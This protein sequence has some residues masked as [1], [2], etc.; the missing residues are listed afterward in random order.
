MLR[1]ANMPRHSHIRVHR[2]PDDRHARRVAAEYVERVVAHIHAVPGGSSQLFAGKLQDS[3]VGLIQANLLGDDYT[4]KKSVQPKLRKMGAHLWGVI[5][6]NTQ[7]EPPGLQP[8]KGLHRPKGRL[9][10]HKVV[11]HEH[12][13]KLSQGFLRQTQSV[14]V[15]PEDIFQKLLVRHTRARLILPLYLLPLPEL[16]LGIGPLH[17]LKSQPR[18]KRPGRLIDLLRD[19]RSFHKQGIVNIKEHT[20]NQCCHTFS[21]PSAVFSPLISHSAVYP[22]S[23]PQTSPSPSTSPRML[24]ALRFS[25]SST[26]WLP[27][28]L[29]LI[30]S[31]T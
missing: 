26:F 10:L 13:P 21:T 3:R 8:L 20:F 2:H 5:A 18:Q 1:R 12:A 23:S 30:W 4:L 11:A 28:W 25:I 17:I 15:H 31:V 6:H 14:S 27:L 7:L 29:T 9:I 19:R 24:S 16:A 22:Q